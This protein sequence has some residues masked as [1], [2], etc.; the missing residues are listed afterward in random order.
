MLKVKTKVYSF[1]AP[2]D[3]KYRHAGV[4]G[5]NLIGIRD[6]YGGS[7]VNGPLWIPTDHSFEWFLNEPEWVRHA[8][9][10]KYNGCIFK[11]E[12]TIVEYCE[13]VKQ[14]YFHKKLKLVMVSDGIKSL[15]ARDENISIV[16]NYGE[17]YDFRPSDIQEIDPDSAIGHMKENCMFLS[18]DVM[19][20]GQMTLWYFKRKETTKYDK[21]LFET[22]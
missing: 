20:P 15:I 16:Y 1:K 9:I 13:R 17:K 4:A 5:C 19:D 6:E 7:T 11:N 10:L 12:N 3:F 21:K 14:L 2:D 8:I 18:Y 22:E